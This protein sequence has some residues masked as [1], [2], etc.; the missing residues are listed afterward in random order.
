MNDA[1]ARSADQSWAPM[2]IL[3]RGCMVLAANLAASRAA[4]LPVDQLLGRRFCDA[5]AHGPCS[6][7]GN[8][9]CPFLYAREGRE[10]REQPRWLPIVSRATRTTALVG[11]RMMAESAEDGTQPGPRVVVTMVLSAA[12]DE[13][14]RK[15]REMVATALHDMRH[16]LAILGI[17]V[18]MMA[19]A[20]GTNIPEPSPGALQRMR[21]VVAQLATN[22]DDLQNRLLFDS[23]VI[24]ITPREVDVVPLIKQLAWQL[25]PLLQRRKQ[26]LSLALPESLMVWA[27]P[28]ALN[29]VL[30]NLLGNAHKYSINGDT[31]EVS[32][33]R[34]RRRRQLEITVRDH[35]H[36]VLLGERSRIFER[37]YRGQETGGA[38]GAGLGLAIVKSLVESQGGE[39]GVGAPRGGGALF[40]ARLPVVGGPNQVASGE[41]AVLTEP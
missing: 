4:G 34:L 29:Q 22:V 2:L 27:D 31:I 11:A 1:W 38:P 18:D 23:G 39:V 25:E 28:S 24:N 21:H 32:A 33:R 19:G 14:D 30:G 35:G 3:D 9:I 26:K 8:Q 12:V 36:G 37:F 20:G 6:V 17:T 41:A 40:W 16:P 13:A 7:P 5:F 15:R 10:R